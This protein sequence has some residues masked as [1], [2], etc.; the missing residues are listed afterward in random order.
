MLCLVLEEQN[1]VIKFPSLKHIQIN[2]IHIY[3]D[4]ANIKTS[5]ETQRKFKTNTGLLL[6]MHI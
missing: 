5:L 1:K 6:T 4:K 3:V 2:K